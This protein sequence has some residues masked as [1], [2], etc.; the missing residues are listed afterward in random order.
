MLYFF[1]VQGY[2]LYPKYKS[3]DYL[4]GVAPLSFFPI[5]LHDLVVFTHEKYG[6]L[7]KEVTQI[8]N[9]KY[10]VE[11]Y[12]DESIDSKHFGWVDKTAILYKV[13]FSIKQ[14]K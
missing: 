11:G 8:E 6:L 9:D 12:N 5:K 14:K 3:G 13:F 10:F 7:V 2:S 4:L 1:K